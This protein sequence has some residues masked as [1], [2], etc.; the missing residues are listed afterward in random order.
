MIRT[1]KRYLACHSVIIVIS[2]VIRVIPVMIYVICLRQCSCHY[3][4]GSVVVVSVYEDHHYY[5]D[6]FPYHYNPHY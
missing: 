3:W 1:F 4:C 2:T 5:S 6:S